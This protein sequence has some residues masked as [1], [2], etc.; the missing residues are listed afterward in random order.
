MAFIA[1]LDAN[2]LHQAVVRDVI[3]S[4]AK[5]GIVQIRW[6][7]DVLDEM[8]R[9]VASRANAP[10]PEIATKGAAYVRSTME[11]AFPDAM[12]DRKAYESL[13]PAMA[14]H[15]KDRH[16]LAACIAGRADVLVTYNLSDFPKESF[17]PYGVEVQHPDVFLVH[18]FG[19][20]PSEV[21]GLLEALAQY[22]SPPLDSCRSIARA[23]RP[24]TPQFADLI[25]KD[26]T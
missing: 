15:P 26:T 14:N 1:F 17:D 13:L 7:P 6:S 20:M 8:E 12:V 11:L 10:S 2:V 16:V 22:R 23:L 18:Q 25:L 21:I 5:A 24:F 19:L 4:I 9:S 3:L